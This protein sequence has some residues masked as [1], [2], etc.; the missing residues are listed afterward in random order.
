MDNPT[1]SSN[2]S[3]AASS[4]GGSI[5]S[6]AAQLGARAGE[7]IASEADARKGM[8]GEQLRQLS[9]AIDAAGNSLGE[10]QSP[11]WVSQGLQSLSQS[12]SRFAE[13]IETR[14][15]RSLASDVQ[16]FAR[17]SPALFLAGCAAAGF[18]AARV[19]RAGASDAS[20]TDEASS[21]GDE[22]SFGEGQG[23]S[24]DWQGGSTAS[25][26]YPENDGSSLGSAG[27]AGGY[28]MGAGL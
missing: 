12:V 6:D 28:G 1:T 5:K 14:D 2:S 18:A 27:S 10:G 8:V 20:S 17:S 3:A 22:G 25:P 24:G 4:A 26:I 16:Q 21:F 15:A 19:L 9:G 11:Q 13:Q 7:R 23:A